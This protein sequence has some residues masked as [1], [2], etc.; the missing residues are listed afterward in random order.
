MQEAAL[1][2]VDLPTEAFR[3]DYRRKR[4]LVYEGLAESYE[5]M[6]PDGA[7]YI[8]PRVPRGSDEEFV[9]RAID[10]NLLLVPG[11]V[12]S[13]HDT[14]FRVSFAADDAVLRRGVELLR[15]LAQD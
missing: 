11:S 4:D 12:F 15:R 14:H 9:T 13:E 7:F 2:A 8:F 10:A 1:A 5:V 3:A 6:R